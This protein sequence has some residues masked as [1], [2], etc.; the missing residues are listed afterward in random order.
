MKQELTSR[1]A[2]WKWGAIG[3]LGMSIVVAGCGSNEGTQTTDQTG[4]GAE[5][6]GAGATFPY[7]LYSKWFDAYKSAKNVAIN[8]QSIGSGGGIQ[9]LKAKTVDFGAS[10]A[11]LKDKDLK[12]M[13]SEVVHIPTVAGSITIVYN[14]P[15]VPKGLK[16]SGAD[17]ADIYLG[18]IKKWNDP[19]L[20]KENAGMKLPD[21]AIAIAHRSD[22]SGTTNI[23]TN[24]LKAVSPEWDKKVGA[25]KSVDWPV[26]LGG[27]GNDGVAAVVQQTPGGLGY[28]ELAYAIENKMSFAALKNKDGEYVEPSVESTTAAI[29]GALPDIQKDVRAPLID[30]AG[31]GA[32]PIAGMT[33]ILAYTKM[34]DP[35]KAKTFTDFLKWAMK[36]G[37]G[38]AKDLYYAPLPPE[39]VAINE[40]T[41][42]SIK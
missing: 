36:D 9:Q 35:A 30:I 18:K 40:Q 34:D 26:G 1:S 19:M 29:A 10:D 39:V 11:P 27:K 37:Q 6:I 23:F 16:L 4:G 2:A 33:Y 21:K 14:L 5:L 3:A 38:M 24:Y 28:V 7:P 25:G 42:A 12:E 22:G 32:Y 15:G 13:P 41:I 31:K 17:V 8:Y 20:M